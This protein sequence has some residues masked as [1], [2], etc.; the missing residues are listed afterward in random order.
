MRALAALPAVKLWTGPSP[1]HELA[2]LRRHLGRGPRLLIKRD[3]LIGFGFGGN[4]VRKMAL[5]AARALEERADTLITT[6][7]VQSNHARTTAVVAATLGLECHLVLNG[8]S[9]SSPTGNLRLAEL[10]GARV[11]YVADRTDRAPAVGALAKRL[12]DEGRRPFVI[13]LGASTP[14]GALGYAQAFAEVLTQI[15]PPDVIVHSTS[16][17]GTQAGLLAGCAMVGARTKVIGISADDPADVTVRR[18]AALLQDMDGVLGVPGDSAAPADA[19]HVDDRFVGAGYGVPT[20]AS[21]EAMRL[22]ARFEGVF[23]DPTY[24][25]KAMAALLAFDRAG[26][27]EESQT[28]LFWHTGGLPGLLA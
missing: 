20:E 19:I 28:V 24:T 14:L 13:P 17:A 15:E 25:A 23:L 5:V 16:S 21:N 10:S 2:R 12:A 27:W 8:A 7:S 22:A 18:V 9:S 3:D 6:G 1:V 4:K 26:S 11:H